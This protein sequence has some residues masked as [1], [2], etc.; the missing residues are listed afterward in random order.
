MQLLRIKMLIRKFIKK[1][2]NMGI[3][4]NNALLMLK[5]KKNGVNFEKVLTIAHRLKNDIEC[6]M[7]IRKHSLS[8]K[9][10][11]TRWK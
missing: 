3:V 7:Q 1:E 4:Y 5:A 2:L 10:F 9:V 11:Y 6:K 8:N